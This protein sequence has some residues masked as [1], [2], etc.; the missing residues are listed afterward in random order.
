ML[1][2]PMF[3]LA[4]DFEESLKT[5]IAVYLT[6]SIFATIQ[7]PRCTFARVTNMSYMS[8]GTYSKGWTRVAEE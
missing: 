8:D 6:M 5:A 1:A 3:I 2:G 4:V 7:A